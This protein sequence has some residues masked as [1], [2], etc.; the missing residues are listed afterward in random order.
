VPI[1]AGQASSQLTSACLASGRGT[2]QPIAVQGLQQHVTSL[3][4]T[5][6]PHQ[7]YS[8]SIILECHQWS[9]ITDDTIEPS[10]LSPRN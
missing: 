5:E 6:A 3:I 9:Q 8:S 2:V 1:F 4:L 10:C 7:W